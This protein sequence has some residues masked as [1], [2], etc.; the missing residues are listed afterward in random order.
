MNCQETLKK[1]A[2]HTENMLD[3]AEVHFGL[4]FLEDQVQPSQCLHVTF[5]KA[6]WWRRNWKSREVRIFSKKDLIKKNKKATSH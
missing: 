4:A 3:L 1:V 2:E 5:E 6:L